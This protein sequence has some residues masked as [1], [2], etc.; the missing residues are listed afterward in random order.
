MLTNSATIRLC[1]EVKRLPMNPSYATGANK[2]QLQL[3][4]SMYSS[5]YKVHFTS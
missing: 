3:D 1:Q 5:W 2:F 4:T